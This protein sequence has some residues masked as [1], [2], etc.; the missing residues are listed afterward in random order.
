MFFTELSGDCGLGSMSRRP[1]KK[2]GARGG[3]PVTTLF[4]ELFYTT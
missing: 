1:E 3:R 2:Q 4:F